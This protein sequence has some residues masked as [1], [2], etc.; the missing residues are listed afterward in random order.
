MDKV[1]FHLELFENPSIR[2]PDFVYTELKE[3]WNDK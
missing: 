2:E 1:G 3:W